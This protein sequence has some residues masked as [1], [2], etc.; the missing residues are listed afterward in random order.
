MKSTLTKEEVFQLQCQVTEL[1]EAIAVMAKD[2]EG[3]HLE[4]ERMRQAQANIT[5]EGISFGKAWISHDG[6]T[7]ERGPIWT[8]NYNEWLKAI[9]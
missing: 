1:E 8:N 5:P 4:N 9:K 7:K 2:K 6:M 3:L